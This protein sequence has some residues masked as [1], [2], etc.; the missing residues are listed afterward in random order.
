LAFVDINVFGGIDGDDVFIVLVL[1]I[2]GQM[3]IEQFHLSIGGIQFVIVDA[4]ED[5]E[6]GVFM[7]QIAEINSKDIKHHGILA[8][9]L[10]FSG[11]DIIMGVEVGG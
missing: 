7:E 4:L 8:N 10:F 2:F 5:V 3:F 1:F 9:S 11:W 6:G